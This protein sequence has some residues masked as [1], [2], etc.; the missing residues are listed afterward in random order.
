[1]IEF[2]QKN[3]RI[4]IFATTTEIQKKDEHIVN[5]P[6][7]HLKTSRFKYASNML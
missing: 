7:N 3:G 5:I 4:L 2:E 6:Q 1:M